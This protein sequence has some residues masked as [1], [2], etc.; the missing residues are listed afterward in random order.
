MTKAVIAGADVDGLGDALAAEG[1][2]TT[3]IDTPA[4]ADSMDAAGL[5]DADLFVLTDLNDATAIPLAKELNP[6]VRVVVYAH[7]TLPEF[8]KGQADLAVDPELLGPEVVAE[9]LVG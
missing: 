4:T 6:D 8:A 3:R 7:D 2:E 5:T 1:V 9:E